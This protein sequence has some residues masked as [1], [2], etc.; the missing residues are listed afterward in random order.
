MFPIDIFCIALSS[1][2]FSLMFSIL[3]LIKSRV[4]V[5]TKFSRVGFKI[6][7]NPSNEHPMTHLVIMLAVPPHVDGRS[8]K[9]S[10]R[11]G[12][13]DEMKRTISWVVQKLDAGEAL[14]VQAQF[15]SIDGETDRTPKFPVL[16]RGD[17]PS[18]FSSLELKADFRDVLAQPINMKL[19]LS[20][21][22][23]HRKV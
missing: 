12:V 23:I 19:N 6:R 3:K 5:S 14:E 13:W 16:V 22:V 21:R 7:A 1:H 4:Q 8:A 2:D 18:I 20:G 10:R 15:E 11:G 9:M 17:Y